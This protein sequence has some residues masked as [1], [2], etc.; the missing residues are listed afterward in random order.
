M[1]KNLL[2]TMFISAFVITTNAQVWD[3][4][5]TDDGWT[6]GQF[7]V[8]TDPEFITLTCKD[9][10]KNPK[11]EQTAANINTEKVHIAAVTLKNKSDKGPGFLRVSY[12]K[13]T[14]D[15]RRYVDL[16]ITNGDT[17]F[18]TYY[19]DLSN[20]KQW[21]GTKNDIRLH[22]KAA[23]NAKFVGSGTEEIEI[24]KIEMLDEIP[25]EK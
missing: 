13:T 2:F 22:F 18:K 17:E 24:D 12:I 14:D 16:D 25:S 3:F 19:F 21:T 20:A 8:S 1:K 11:F 10:A 15:S 7:K 4:N 6:T 5:G 9:G 23:G